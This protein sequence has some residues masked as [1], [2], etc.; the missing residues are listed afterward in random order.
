MVLLEPF[1]RGIDESTTVKIGFCEPLL[2]YVKHAKNAPRSIGPTFMDRLAEPS[3]PAVIA[4]LQSG[5]DQSLFRT[6]VIVEAHP[7]RAGSLK[8]GFRARGVNAVP[9]DELL[10]GVE[11]AFPRS[12]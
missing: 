8:N 1:S 7:R 12:V 11:Q 2:Q 5:H 9:V 10:C 6:E 4:A 3:H